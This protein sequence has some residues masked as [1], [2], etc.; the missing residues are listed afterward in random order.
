[1]CII[2]HLCVH[3]CVSACVCFIYKHSSKWPADPRQ[4]L[5]PAL[6]GPS[7]KSIWA[8]TKS[9]CFTGHAE[10]HH[11]TSVTIFTA[12]LTSWCYR[13]TKHMVLQSNENVEKSHF[14]EEKKK[15]ICHLFQQTRRT[16][17]GKMYEPLGQQ[18]RGCRSFLSQ[19][20]S[21]LCNPGAGIKRSLAGGKAV[22]TAAR[23]SLL[24]ATVENHC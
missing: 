22:R 2:L 21:S 11:C 12:Q 24:S 14:V 15:S 19:D 20:E 23:R 17:S 7:K 5:R 6:L 16:T 4:R 9:R 1:M 8:P 10:C 3:V 13:K 18:R